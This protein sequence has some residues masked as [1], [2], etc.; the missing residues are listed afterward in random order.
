M[1][2][3]FFDSGVGGLSVLQT[4]IK[5][6]PPQQ[7]IYYADSKNAPYGTKS[8][9]EVKSLT[10]QVVD[11]L[12]KKEINAL[13]IAC[14]TATSIAVK[15]LRKE[16]DFP[17]IGMEPAIKPAIEKSKNKKVLLFATQLTLKEKKLQLLLQQLNANH[18]VDGIALSELI[19]FAEKMEW[20]K[21]KVTKYL[22]KKLKGIEWKN[23]S[24]IVLGCTHFLFFKSHFKKLIP[25]HIE[26]IDG[27]LGTI[28][29]L[30]NQI[31]LSSALEK[32][33][34]DFFISGKKVDHSVFQPHLDWLVDVGR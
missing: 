27:N 18:K 32:N 10:F 31:H 14:N 23:Y 30:K 26:I 2:I 5:V 20:H 22:E 12:H 11:F 33:K 17:I 3:G 9:K 6:L 34:F 24:S 21:K 7:Y 15:K 8:K 25:P 19:P 4:A 29:H 1:K 13:V 28:L 16:Y